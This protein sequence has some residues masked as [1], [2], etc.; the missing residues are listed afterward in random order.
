MELL[1]LAVSSTPST[2]RPLPPD[3]DSHVYQLDAHAALELGFTL[4]S[5][6]VTANTKLLVMD[7]VRSATV[8]RG[9]RTQRWGCGYRLEVAVGEVAAEGRL[10]LPAIAA[11]VEIGST[12]ASVSLSVKGYTANDLWDVIPPP[13]PLDVDTYKTYLEA[14]SAIQ[15]RFKA[16][17]DGAVSVLLASSDAQTDMLIDGVQEA[18]LAASVAAVWALRSLEA[19]RVLAQALEDFADEDDVALRDVIGGTYRAIRLDAYDS[20]GTPSE[21]ERAKARLYL[22][23]AGL[24]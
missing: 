7:T 2:P 4:G 17:G 23:T 16:L 5:V 14:A 8:R 3:W 24:G 20:S 19:G 18:D 10:T 6:A 22:A 21:A 15:Q 9:R 11:S 12:E 13:R 1:P